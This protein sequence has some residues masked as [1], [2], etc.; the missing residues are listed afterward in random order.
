LPLYPEL[1]AQLKEP[2]TFEQVPSV[3]QLSVPDVHSFISES[4]FYNFSKIFIDIENKRTTRIKIIKTVI[5]NIF[6]LPVQVT[7]FPLY[8]EL[9]AQV[10]P[11]T[12]LLH[13]AL[14]LQVSVPAVHSLMSKISM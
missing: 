2:A 12:V 11:P 14:P 10:N 6:Y 3:E 13:A 9:H 4:I 8:P 7:P 5:L 1:Q